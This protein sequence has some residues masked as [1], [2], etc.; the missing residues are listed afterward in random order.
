MGRERWWSGHGGVRV[1]GSARARLL[2][3]ALL[4]EPPACALLLPRTRAV[5]TL[6]MRFALDLVWLDAEGRA[7][8]IDRAVG[9]HR[10]RA[11]RAAVA[12]CEIPNVNRDGG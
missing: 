4:R 6:G 2:G 10:F 12:V 3:L 8:R 11:C 7:V 9:S 5:H 1:A